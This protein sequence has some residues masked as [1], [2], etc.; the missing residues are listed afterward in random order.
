MQEFQSDLQLLFTRLSSRLSPREMAD[1]KPIGEKLNSLADHREVKINHSIMEV[2]CASHLI[3][4]GYRVDV[5]HDMGEGIVCDLWGKSA[6]GEEVAIEVETGFVP[7]EEALNPI[8]YRRARITSKTARYSIVSDK[9]GLAIPNY[10]ILQIPKVLTLPMGERRSGDLLILLKECAGYYKNP[11][12]SLM[13]LMSC[14]L[15]TI[16]IIWID[17]CRVAEMEP[18]EYFSSYLTSSEKMI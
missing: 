14:H 9:F 12:I 15:D 4:N 5:E 17:D 6:D 7:P 18:G 2:I 13:E 3:A 8:S 1:L 16:Y 11:P 10:H